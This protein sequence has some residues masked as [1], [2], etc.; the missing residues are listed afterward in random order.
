MS[1]S[2]VCVLGVSVWTFQGL[3]TLAFGAHGLRRG[4][5]SLAANAGWN[6]ADFFVIAG[7]LRNVT[8]SDLSLVLAGMNWPL[9][10]RLP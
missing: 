5:H 9:W 3:L 4:L 7:N 1:H 8:F 2:G 6:R 10:R